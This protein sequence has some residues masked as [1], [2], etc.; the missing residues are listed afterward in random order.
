[1]KPTEHIAK[2]A[3]T[4]KTGLFATLR[5]LLSVRG[6]GASSRRLPVSVLAT[7]LGALA[8]TASSALAT[9]EFSLV[10][11]LAPSGGSFG[12]L[13]PNSVAVSDVSGDRFVADS[14]TGVV[15]VFNA[16]GDQVAV[17]DGSPTANP[18]GVPGGKFAQAVSVATNARTGNVYVVDARDGVVDEFDENGK[19]VGQIVHN[20]SSATG[21]AVDQTT[22][23]VYV[24]DSKSAAIDIFSREDVYL[25]KISLSLIPGG[26]FHENNSA[27]GFAVND[28][29]GHVY[30]PAAVPLQPEAVYD[31]DAAGNYVA[32]WDGANTPSGSFLE[33]DSLSVAANGA[34]GHV[35]VTDASNAV[36]DVFDASG[37]YLEQLSYPY[38]EARGT[39]VDPASGTVY[40]SDNN[41]GE[42]DVFAP[43]IPEAPTVGNV[44][45]A[46]LTA[47]SADLKAQI[48]PD[49]SNTQYRFEYGETASYGTSVPLPEGEAGAGSDEVTVSQHVEGLRPE[50]L[51]HYRVV[52]HN[53]SGTVTSGDHTFITYEAPPSTGETCPNSR[54]RVGYAALLPECRAYEQVTPDSMEPNFQNFEEPQ[55]VVEP[56]HHPLGLGFGVMAST[57]GNRIAFDAG[58][59]APGAVGDSEST[60]SVRGPQGWSTRS[61]VPPQSPSYGVLCMSSVLWYSVDL[62]RAIQL[63]NYS[64]PECS[65]NEPL[66]PDEPS[67]DVNVLVR[68][69][70]EGSSRLANV[71]PSGVQPENAYFEAASEDLSHVLFIE[72]AKLTE[73]APE[74][75]NLY[76]WV[77]GGVHLVTVLPDGSPVV[78][79]LANS[80]PPNATELPETFTHALS[81]DGGRVFFYANGN[82]YVRV[83]ADREQS[84]L[85]GTGQCTEPERACTYQVDASKSG[86]SGGGG[87]FMWASAD[88]SR[89]FFT[90]EGQLT[91]GAP[92][93]AGEPDMYEYN[94]DTGDL[95]DLT[96]GA[97]QAAGVI[98]VSGAAEDGSYVYFVAEAVLTGQPNSN[99]DS[100]QAGQPN[101]YVVHNG[102]QPAFIAMLDAGTDHMDWLKTNW[103]ENVNIGP[104][105]L[106][107]RVSPNGRYVV[108]NSL[109]SLTG[110]DNAPAS[111][112]ECNHP[113]YVQQGEPSQPC[114]EIFLYDA[115]KSVLRCVSCDPTGARP[116]APASI[117]ETNE[118]S[119]LDNNEPYLLPGYLQR[120][121]MNDGRVFFDTNSSLVPSDTNDAGDVYVYDEGRLSLLSTGTSSNG[122]Y[123]YDASPDGNNVFFVSPQQLPSGAG[124]ATYSIYDARVDGGFAEPTPATACSEEDCKGTVAATPTLS[125][126]SSQTFVGPGNPLSA[127]APVAHK[128]TKTK[129]ANP[130]HVKKRRHKKRQ[131]AK[132]KHGKGKA[133][134]VGRRGR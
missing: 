64:H 34:T 15:Y 106:T 82:L 60:F 30:V 56:G 45:V 5:G 130:K 89:V 104:P 88:G 8:F 111:P 93:M 65:R 113:G 53:A 73:N 39:A 122:S 4:S 40:V 27:F 57:D 55:N 109:R 7:T 100:A 29:N 42:V 46:N 74:G 36:T 116:V 103:E 94:V 91:N 115:V 62:T 133:S 6:T 76:E 21:V 58:K 71:T 13:G 33:S 31:F 49:L 90:D 51:Y 3:S 43:P 102:G 32:A 119:L 23:E 24:L 83:H 2:S 35:Y 101:L 11:K 108:F 20:F 61:P 79:R 134:Y 124:T 28:F 114:Q 98:G 72:S 38:H 68:N 129:R 117:R 80:H 69:L 25:R 77:E 86:G 17:W 120:F 9:P 52:I 96:A 48:D 22:G 112:G 87:R 123:F 125:V 70:D 92:A 85:G 67:E 95:A 16:A 19:Y 12:L 121:L 118:P 41:P 66:L 78:G 84:L 97:G 26:Y 14:G 37:V 99:G 47:S 75:D 54:Y 110:Y 132:G 10:G 131:V 127:P 59:P 63:D 44:S 128:K 107:A 1:V 81:S 105:A 18:P 50:T 126:P